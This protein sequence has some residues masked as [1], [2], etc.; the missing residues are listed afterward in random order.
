M[1]PHAQEY[2]LRHILGLGP[3]PQHSPAQIQNARQVT[4]HQRARGRV[5]AIG[6]T[7][8]EVTV[9]ILHHAVPPRLAVT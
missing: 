7:R 4:R 8:H 3:A 2:V 1:R 9:G 5:I 6:D